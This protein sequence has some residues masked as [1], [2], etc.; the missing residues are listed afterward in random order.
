[1]KNLMI[2]RREY[3]DILPEVP[4]EDMHEPAGL[5]SHLLK[6]VHW[7]TRYCSRAECFFVE[8]LPELAY[9]VHLGPVQVDTLK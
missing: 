1:M 2:T 3:Y 9:H 8:R 7:W 6:A 5:A 4:Q